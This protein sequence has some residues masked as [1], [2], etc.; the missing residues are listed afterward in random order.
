M[1]CE[2]L[3]GGVSHSEPCRWMLGGVRGFRVLSVCL[4]RKV[5]PGAT[6]IS[7]QA[8]HCSMGGLCVYLGQKQVD[9]TKSNI[10]LLQVSWLVT[11]SVCG[12]RRHDAFR[13]SAE[14]RSPVC[15]QHPAN[16]Y[17]SYTQQQNNYF[18]LKLWETVAVVECYRSD[19]KTHHFCS[20]YA[21]SEHNLTTFQ[22]S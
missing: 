5:T 16:N 4:R 22:S 7:L 13:L 2:C 3:W 20:I 6:R 1:E 18:L 17:C 12:L 14:S 11:L 8:A 15:W 10:S 21:P 9:A 19:F